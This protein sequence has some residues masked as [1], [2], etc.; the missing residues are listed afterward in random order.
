[1]RTIRHALS[2][3]LIAPVLPR[4]SFEQIQGQGFFDMRSSAGQV[5]GL[6]ALTCMAGGFGQLLRRQ[7]R[8]EGSRGRF[9]AEL[10]EMR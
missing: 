7:L 4:P 3:L 8:D 2:V 5:T 6:M 10:F 1:M 9:H